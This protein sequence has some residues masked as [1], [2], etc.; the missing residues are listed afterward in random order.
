MRVRLIE[1]AAKIGVSKSAVSMA[2]HNNAKIPLKRRK[3]MANE[4][5]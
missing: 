5:L 3:Y 4:R 2:L 1:I